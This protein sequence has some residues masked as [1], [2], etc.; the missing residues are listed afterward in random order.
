MDEQDKL[1][2]NID[3]RRPASPE[4]DLLNRAEAPRR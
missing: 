1:G 3:E 4:V 2:N